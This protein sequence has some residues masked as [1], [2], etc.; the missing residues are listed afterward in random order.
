MF[1]TLRKSKAIGHIAL[2][3]VGEYLALARIELKLRE[4]Q[5][6]HRVIGAAT[7]LLLLLLALIFF[8]I[9]LL[10]TW[11][12]SPYRTAVAWLVVGVLVL[13]A[14]AGVLIARKRPTPHSAFA[15]LQ[16]QLHRDIAVIKENL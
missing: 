7:A 2:D 11:W 12:D 1:E 16:D 3:R 15:A 14:C 13:G 4:E 9:A 5:V 6:L 10:V 8:C